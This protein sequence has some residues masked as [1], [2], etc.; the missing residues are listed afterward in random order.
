MYFLDKNFNYVPC[1]C[2]GCNDMMMKAIS[3]N[4]VAITTLK[5]IL[6]EL[7]FFYE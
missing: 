1:P 6:T 3:F 4:D 7:I 2:N 5:E